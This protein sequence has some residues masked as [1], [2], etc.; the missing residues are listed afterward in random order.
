LNTSSSND[1]EN[2]ISEEDRGNEGDNVQQ[3]EE[4]EEIT[5]VAKSQKKRGSN[6]KSQVILE[7]E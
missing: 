3:L 2:A 1:E 7:Q 6:K 5:I 4:P